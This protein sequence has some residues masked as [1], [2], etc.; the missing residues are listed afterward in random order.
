MKTEMASYHET[1]VAIYQLT[2][3][4]I[5]ELTP[6]HHLCESLKI[7]KFH[8]IFGWSLLGWQQET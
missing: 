8:H 4:H 1:S 2:W 6:P 7:H 5:P 3:H